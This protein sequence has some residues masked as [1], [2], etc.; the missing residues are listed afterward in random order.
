M[1]HAPFKAVRNSDRSDDHGGLHGVS[2]DEVREAVLEHSYWSAPGQ[3]G[4]T[5]VYGLTRAG[6]HLLVVVVAE[7][8][9][10]SGGRR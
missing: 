3:E 8:D 6:R 9:V 7:G 4:T 5:L 2:Q 1:P 10:A